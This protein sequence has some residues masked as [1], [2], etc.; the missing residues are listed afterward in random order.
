MVAGCKTSAPPPDM[1]AAPP[2]RGGVTLAG[3]AIATPLVSALARDFSARHPGKP[4]AVESPL[5]T[6]GGLLAL[7]AKRLSGALVVTT[8][9]ATPREGALFLGSTRVVVAVGPGVRERRLRGPDL[10]QLV[11]GQTAQWTNGQPVHVLLGAP[12]NLAERALSHRLEGLE[13]AIIDARSTHRWPVEVAA[14]TRRTRLER[15]SGAVSIATE[16]NL[17]LEGTAAWILTLEDTDAANVFLWLVMG[18]DAEPR[19]AAF[20]RFTASTAAKSIMADFG[21][22]PAP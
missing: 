4:I 17:R 14:D 20:A 18:E 9:P 22:E 2:T 6:I 7:D 5:G 8:E 13:R 1:T 21:F 10:V 19:I 3:D 16:G 15:T 12:G 11:A